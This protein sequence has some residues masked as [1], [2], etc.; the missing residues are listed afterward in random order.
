MKGQKKLICFS[1]KLLPH[2]EGAWPV[3]AAV[4]ADSLCL[5]QIDVLY[6]MDIFNHAL[7]VIFIVR[8]SLSLSPDVILCG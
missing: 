5:A 7:F 3:S 2:G 1:W 6:I 8:L 4:Y